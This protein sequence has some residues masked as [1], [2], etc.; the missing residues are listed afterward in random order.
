MSVLPGQIVLQNQVPVA[1]E[2]GCPWPSRRRCCQHARESL[3]P[4]PVAAGRDEHSGLPV[5]PD[6]VAAPTPKP[7]AEFR[8]LNSRKEQ[9]RVRR[10]RL[11]KTKARWLPDLFADRP[12]AGRW[13]VVHCP[14][15]VTMALKGLF[16]GLARSPGLQLGPL[17]K[18]FRSA[19][20]QPWQL[21]S[22]FAGRS[23]PG[24]V[25]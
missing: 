8:W 3:G 16:P 10:V 21:S 14:S 23:A 2:Q 25:L 1:V 17:R 9:Q 15:V 6:F 7:A 22:R 24:Q 5:P 19:E 11:K 20:R 18:G 13:V 4:Q 12:E